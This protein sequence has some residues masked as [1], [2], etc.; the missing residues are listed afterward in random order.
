VDEQYEQQ[1][2]LLEGR[3]LRDEGQ[4]KVKEHNESWHERAMKYLRDKFSCPLS[5][6]DM[7]FYTH[8]GGEFTSED[9]RKEIVLN[10]GPPSH[11]NAWGALITSA[12]R[13]G[14]IE[15]TGRTVQATNKAAHARRLPVWR[16]R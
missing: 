2:N 6:S 7:D 1:L 4:A 11:P 8:I 15:D 13:A 5:E 16:F 3:R 9:F 14:I 10:L 12:V